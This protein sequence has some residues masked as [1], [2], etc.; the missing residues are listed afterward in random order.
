LQRLAL[1]NNSRVLFLG[2]LGNFALFLFIPIHQKPEFDLPFH[3]ERDRLLRCE[4]SEIV[5]ATHVNKS[6]A[7]LTKVDS[8][9]SSPFAQHSFI[10]RTSTSTSLRSVYLFSNLRA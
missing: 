6:H 8:K 7:R 3:Q 5:D 4:V 2:K 9:L 1:S 10:A